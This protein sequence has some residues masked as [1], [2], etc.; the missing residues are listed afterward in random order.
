MVNIFVRKQLFQNAP[1]VL[2]HCFL[3]LLSRI[4]ILLRIKACRIACRINGHRVRVPNGCR[5]HRTVGKWNSIFLGIGLFNF[6]RTISYFL[7][8]DTVVGFLGFHYGYPRHQ[9]VH[10]Q[11]WHRCRHVLWIIQRLWSRQKLKIGFQ[12]FRPVGVV[13]WASSLYKNCIRMDWGNNVSQLTKNIFLWSSSSRS[14]LSR[15][16]LLD[17]ASFS[18]SE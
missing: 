11:R 18:L 13:V 16:L 9:D 6:V 12:N 5:F 7:C 15:A 3:Q 17:R 14:W 1:I 4:S 10:F 8:L 2:L